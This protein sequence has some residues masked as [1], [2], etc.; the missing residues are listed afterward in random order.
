LFP[1]S[2]TYLTGLAFGLNRIN[3][4]EKEARQSGW[5]NQGSDKQHV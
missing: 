4:Q 3:A 1:L 2:Q 5:V